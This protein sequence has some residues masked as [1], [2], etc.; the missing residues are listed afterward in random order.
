MRSYM[1]YTLLFISSLLLS[2]CGD[3]GGTAAPV[4]GT[5]VPVSTTFTVSVDAPD[6]IILANQSSFSLIQPAY[7]NAVKDLTEQNFAAVWLDGQGKV[8]DSINITR[9]ESQGDGRY[10]LDAG[11][12]P[13]INAVLLVDLDGVPEFTIGENLPTGLYMTPLAA[14][15]LAIS[16][17]SSLT[18]YALAQRVATDASWGVFTD[19]FESGAQGA[20]ALALEDI[21]KIAIDIRDTLF[22]KIGVQGLTL[23]DLMSL[24]IVQTM[25]EGRL[26]RYF[27]EQSAVIANILAI[28]NDGYWEISATESNEGKGI[29]ADSTSYDGNE[30]IITE[31]SW[32]KAGSEDI[33]LS[34]VFTYLSNSTTFGSEDIRSQ[35][36][37]N[38]G[39]VGLFEYLKVQFSTDRNALLTDAALNTSDERGVTLEARVYPLSGKKMHDFLSSREN[40]Y[41]TRYIPD[42]TTFADGSSGFY[43]TWRPESETYL[44]CDN[45]ND[46]D[47]CRAYPILTPDAGYTSLD[48]IKTPLFDIGI[49]IDQVNGFK[50]SDNIVAEFISD[51]FFTV[52]YWSRIA[53]NEWTIQDTGVW[54][55]ATASGRPVIRFDVP[56]IIRQ[57]ADDY[58]YNG[59]NLFLVEDRGFVNIGE[60]LLE[61]AE[62][63]FSGFD[64]DAKAQ[65]FAA[66]SRDNLPP[67]GE[68][69]FG[70]TGF[71]N[72]GLF[73][74]AVTECGGDERFTTQ[75]VND[76]VDKTLVQISEEGEIT[77]HILRADNTWDH[78]RNTLEETG[79][80]SWSLTEE[81]Y[82]KLIGDTNIEDEFD[83]WSLNGYEYQ[84]N[85]LAIKVFSQQ[86]QQAQISSTMAKEYLAGSLAACL[87]GD[88]GWDPATATPVVKE[89]LANYN[90]Q[91][92]QCKEIWFGRN[93]VF[94]EALL[95]GQT[96]N[97]SDDKA[98]IFASDTG[99]EGGDHSNPDTARYLKL[100]DDFQGD[101]FLGSYVDGSGCGFNFD[102]LWK[103]EDDGTLYYEAVDGSMN[104]RI[105]ITDT[106]GLKLAIKAFNHQSRWQTD[107]TL[108]YGS[109]EGEIWSD[110]VT[111][112]DASQVP[113]VVPVEPP[114]PAEEE[115]PPEG[116]TPPA[117]GEEPPA[118][119][120]PAGPPAGTILNDGQTCA[121]LEVPEEPAP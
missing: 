115:T 102:I 112:I 76:L 53:A 87:D 63:N 14:E 66:A 109:D 104:E 31:Y 47:T 118:E 117:E 55:P 8:F 12:R 15:R 120:E 113:N 111:L 114:P 103:I 36:L 25:T 39:W 49:T 64:N 59:R 7:A 51:D 11:T 4:A 18:Y 34:E 93:P 86:G 52:R 57:I 106:D 96:G 44:L 58:P 60:V 77:A 24:T 26:E 98:L 28:L 105:Q 54:A 41:L 9:L 29:F 101:F 84:R 5:P 95:I 92:Q 70:N 1:G 19:V 68:C 80:R 79:S 69:I 6:G 43:F 38:Q 89:T 121:Y 13:R 74:N 62:F 108:L 56:D 20:V 67:F 2:A 61:L 33:T 71:A 119:E 40:H 10:V 88:S 17:E 48:D 100:S 50:L 65:I 35:V 83:Y 82:L 91:V 16:L 72:E 81:G 99:G 37:T 3:S 107:E 116:E 110:I 23:E 73:L 78:Y 42:D 21:N 85:L 46:Q 22:P 97:N 27:T 45:T 32:D 94:T 90:T 30:T 75:S